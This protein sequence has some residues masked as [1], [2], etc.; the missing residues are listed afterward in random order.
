MK[1][2]LFL[3]IIVLSLSCGSDNT[4][5][6]NQPKTDVKSG[7]YQM[8]VFQVDE[9]NFNIVELNK[10]TGDVFVRNSNGI[11]YHAKNSDTLKKYD[12]PVYEMKLIKGTKDMFQIVL[13]DSK[14][15]NAYVRSYS[16]AWYDASGVRDLE[17]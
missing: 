3:F 2:L 10:L 13:F 8:D 15:G 17:L 1:N 14:N 5:T 12:Y 6:E 11:W 16:S 4:K 9:V 7:K